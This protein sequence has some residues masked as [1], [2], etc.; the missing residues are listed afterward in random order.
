LKVFNCELFGY[1]LA[2]PAPEVIALFEN[3]LAEVVEVGLF[4]TLNL[5]GCLVTELIEEVN[6]LVYKG[7]NLLLMLWFSRC[8]HYTILDEY[9]KYI[10]DVLFNVSKIHN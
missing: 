2:K 9:T 3:F 6:C 4:A 7:A 10:L 1:N 8:A 5:G